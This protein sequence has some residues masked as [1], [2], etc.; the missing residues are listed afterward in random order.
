M[1]HSDSSRSVIYFTDNFKYNL[2][3]ASRIAGKVVRPQMENK[4]IIKSISKETI[5]L[6]KH[7]AQIIQN[8]K[9]K[10]NNKWFPKLTITEGRKSYLGVNEILTYYHIRCDHYLGLSRCVTS[11]KTCI[12][13][14]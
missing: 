5:L 10:R 11:T 6:I 7:K 13:I 4:G 8:F 14:E 1:I 9:T 2:T 12:C 3:E